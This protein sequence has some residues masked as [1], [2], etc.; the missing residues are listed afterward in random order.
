ML[1]RAAQNRY[2]EGVTMAFRAAKADE[3]AARSLWGQGFGPAAEL[4]V[5]TGSAGD[6]VAGGP[7]NRVF[8]RAFATVIS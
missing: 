4:Y 3:D 1:P 2:P 6:L 7:A 5:S 8:N